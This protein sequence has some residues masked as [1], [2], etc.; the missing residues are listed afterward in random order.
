MRRPA[1]R[2]RLVLSAANMRWQ[3]LQEVIPQAL[4]SIEGSLICKVWER[5]QRILKAYGWGAVFG[6]E[7]Y[8]QQVFKSHRRAGV[9]RE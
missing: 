6:D 7:A 4:E 9:H 8:K 5:S 2:M 1:V 3:G